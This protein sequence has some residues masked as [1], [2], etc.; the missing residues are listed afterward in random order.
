MTRDDPATRIEAAT[1]AANLRDAD[2]AAPRP[3]IRK[4]SSLALTAL[5]APARSRSLVADLIAGIVDAAGRGPGGRRWP[6]SAFGETTDPRCVQHG[7]AGVLGVLVQAFHTLG[8]NSLLD[9]AAKAAHWLAARVQQPLSGPVGLQFGASGPAWALAA[10]AGALED[11][12]LLSVAVDHALRQPVEWPSPDITHGR[13]GLGLTLL[14]MWWQTG[15]NR[16]LAQAER[17]AET[18]VRDAE[19]EP[20]GSV[21]WRTPRGVASTFAGKRFYGF[22]HGT[23]GIGLFLL[24]LGRAT[25]REDCLRLAGSAVET[26]LAAAVT[27]DG[28]TSWGP[29]PEEPM[30]TLPHWC[31]GASGVGTFLLRALSYTGEDRLRGVLDGAARSVMAAKWSSGIS[32]CHCPDAR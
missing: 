26:L 14:Q 3:S 28:T 11:E 6:S 24:E 4:L 27:R 31:N 10:A 22:A 32:Y 1:V 13:A 2:L 9:E 17:V 12:H 19:L 8:D 15:D 16:L 23:A 18:L 20:D 30:P 5:E 25:G 29:S 7:V 21:S